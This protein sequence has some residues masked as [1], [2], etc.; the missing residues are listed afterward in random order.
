MKSLGAHLLPHQL[1]VGVKAG[2]EVMP[3]LVRQWRDDNANDPDKFLINYDEGNAHNEVD[4]HTFLTRMR[5]IAPGICKWLEY[6]YPTDVATYVFYRG[7]A[8]ESRAGGQQGC[9]LIGACHAV[10]KRM[11]HESLGL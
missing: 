1:A 7:R 6:I 3:H 2:V 4:R 11:V 8:I 9:P 5:D 10:V